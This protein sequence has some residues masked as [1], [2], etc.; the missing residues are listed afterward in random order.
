VRKQLIVLSVGNWKTKACNPMGME[1][2]N[3]VANLFAQESQQ[4]MLMLADAFGDQLD[5]QGLC[6]RQRLYLSWRF[7][8]APGTASEP[9]CNIACSLASAQGVAPSRGQK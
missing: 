4:L 2:V 3:E 9:I 7:C 6:I 1:V 8:P 5:E